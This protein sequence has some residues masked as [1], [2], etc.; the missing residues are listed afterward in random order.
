P[1][2]D[3]I[4]AEAVEIASPAER[5]AFVERAC[6]GD[7]GLK[8]RVE[9]L[10][11]HHFQAGSFL[12]S[13]PANFDATGAFTPSMEDGSLAA[14]IPMEDPGTVIG[15]SKLLEQIGEGGMGLVY[16][17]EQQRPVMR[18]V[19]LKIIKPGMD[20][21]QVIARFEAE[22][23]ALAMMDHS[24]IAKVHDGGTTPEGRPYF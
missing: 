3:A 23:Q 9:H 21:R 19:A 14:T 8:E 18:R 12:D 15:P 5:H 16:V 4:L 2:I 24:N 10:I 6:A 17:A 11:A 22:R 20:S 13:P 1:T 7:A